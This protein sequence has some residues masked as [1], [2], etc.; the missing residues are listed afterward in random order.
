[1]RT[2]DALHVALIVDGLAVFI[3]RT[4]TS[5]VEQSEMQD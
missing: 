2:R 3:G 4:L 5:S 1:M